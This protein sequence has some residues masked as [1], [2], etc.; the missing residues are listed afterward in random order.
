MTDVLD[1]IQAFYKDPD[2][3]PGWFDGQF[4]G[5]KPRGKAAIY[6]LLLIVETYFTADPPYFKDFKDVTPS[7]L[8]WHALFALGELGDPVSL[9]LLHRVVLEGGEAAQAK[10]RSTQ[11]ETGL[12]V[13]RTAVVACWKLGDREPL[14]ERIQKMRRE[15]EELKQSSRR[16]ITDMQD[17]AAKIASVYWDLA[18]LLSPL[19]QTEEVIE[20]YR[21]YMAW[22]AQDGKPNDTSMAQY[23]AQYNIACAYAKAERPREAL[24]ALL[25]AVQM[26]YTEVN[27]P[28]KDGDLAALHALPEFN[29]A[30]AMAW[31]RRN[32]GPDIQTEPKAENRRNA[33]LQVRLAMERG[34]SDPSWFS[35]A[36][37]TSLR[38]EPE[39][40]WCAARCFAR[41]G[42]AE[43]CA[44]R[45]AR[46]AESARAQ[47]GEPDRLPDVLASEDFVKVKDHPAVRAALAAAGK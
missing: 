5:L 37:F 11:S 25:K 9:P 35:N 17:R 21:K 24:T 3:S 10:E 39:F 28:Q 29:L 32:A 38:E 45:I 33:L 43:A 27:W 42:D 13:E 20:C 19:D 15:I 6:A 36:M 1:F 22:K 16:D 30:L 46:Y 18:I 2:A 26:G 8:R 4:D 7:R 41:A 47:G 40:H 14:L 23:M 12:D 31:L 34:L 44:A